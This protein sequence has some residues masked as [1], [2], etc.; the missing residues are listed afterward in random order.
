M[1]FMSILD[2]LVR[3]LHVI[4]G[5]M[6]IGLLYFFNF[7]NGPFVLTMDGPTKKAVVPELMPRALYWFRWGAA[8]TWVTGVLLLMLVFYH[9]GIMF[10][11]DELTWGAGAYISLILVFGSVFIY[12]ALMTSELFGDP[13]I[14]NAVGFMLTTFLLLIMVKS[15]LGVRSYMI[16]IGAMFGTIMAFNVWFRIWPAQQKIIT[17][18]KNGEAPPDGL[19]A[20]AGLR[21]K[22]NTYLSVPLMWTMLNAHT[23]HVTFFGI[24]QWGVLLIMILVGWHIV[25]QFYNKAGKI[26]GF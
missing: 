21:S 6:W 5:V 20:L 13:K 14:K 22:H 12:D 7:V 9:G 24:A 10:A 4:A 15:G 26:K 1:E 11:S 8:Y 3:W 2:P 19:P 17:A 25:F 18:I 16:H 23:A